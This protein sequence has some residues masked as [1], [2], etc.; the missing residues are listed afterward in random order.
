MEAI[1]SGPEPIAG[2]IVPIDMLPTEILTHI[3]HLLVVGQPPMVECSFLD[4]EMKGSHFPKY[5]DLLAHV[6][7]HWRKVAISS[8]ALWSY[9]DITSYHQLTRGFLAR[10]GTHITRAGRSPLHI[11]IFNQCPTNVHYPLDNQISLKF[12]PCDFARIKSL[13]LVSTHRFRR[14]HFKILTYTLENCVSGELKRLIISDGFVGPQRFIESADD[15]HHADSALLGLPKEQLEDILLHVDV[16]RLFGLYPLWTSQAYHGLVD[17]RLGPDRFPNSTPTISESQLVSILK[18][19]PG[20]RIFHFNLNLTGSLPMVASVVPVPLVELERLNLWWMKEGQLDILLRWLAP[21]TKHLQ[22][23]IRWR[24]RSTDEFER[25]LARSNITRFRTTIN[26]A[27]PS[28]NLLELMPSLH[29][30]VVCPDPSSQRVVPKQIETPDPEAPTKGVFLDTLYIMAPIY[31][32]VLVQTIKRYSVQKLVLRGSM[33]VIPNITYEDA[34]R[35]LS[36]LCTIFGDLTRGGT[37]P[38]PMNG[39]LAQLNS[40]GLW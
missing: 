32:D 40:S 34:Y 16:L 26:L 30:L 7:S 28:K 10:A 12:L 14:A 37:D 33:V 23:S 11:Y 13:E 4:N 8:R 31:L 18:S 5:P 29:T 15:A 35:E 27:Y 1:G 2:V 22:V 17:L 19:S 25:F 20:L 24:L 6:C 38:G 21:G 39:G 36:P 3:F 9:I